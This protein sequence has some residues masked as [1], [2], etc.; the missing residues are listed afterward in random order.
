MSNCQT[1][2]NAATTTAPIMAMSVKVS[3]CRMIISL[4][5]FAILVQPISGREAASMV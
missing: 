1:P 3:R 5:P 4:K 2:N